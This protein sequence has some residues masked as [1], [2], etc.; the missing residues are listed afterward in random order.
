MYEM[1]HVAVNMFLSPSSNEFCVSKLSFVMA[2]I[3]SPENVND[4]V[5]MLPASQQPSLA[6]QTNRKKLLN[7]SDLSPFQ[8]TANLKSSWLPSSRLRVMYSRR[9]IINTRKHYMP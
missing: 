6:S 1:L 2:D 4:A 9:M 7:F 3:E 8:S 5:K